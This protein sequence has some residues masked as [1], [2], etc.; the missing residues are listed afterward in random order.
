MRTLARLMSGSTHRFYGKADLLATEHGYRILLDGH[1]MKTPAGADFLLPTQALARAVVDEWLAQRD[2]IRIETLPATRLAATAID[3]VSV[4]RQAVVDE[5]R[6]C[7]DFDLLFYRASEPPDLALRQEA[8]WQPLLDWAADL[9]GI[10]FNV[11]TGVMPVS[12]PAGMAEALVSAADRLGDME[13]T[14]LANVAQTSGSLVI[15]LALA[16]KRIDAAA[17]C[18][19]ALLD[20]TF[21]TERWGMPREIFERRRRLTDDIV[22]ADRFIAWCR[23]AEPDM[24]SAGRSGGCVH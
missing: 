17:A 3:L 16:A 7:A 2:V 1:A 5:L 23:D 18:E 8:C 20:E 13:L 14:G 24:G 19:A 12:Q 4:N 6:A 22:F 21:Q 11:T 10:P 9:W 15:A